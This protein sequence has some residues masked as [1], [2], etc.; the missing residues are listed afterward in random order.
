MFVE[1]LVVD[2]EE[3]E[4]IVLCVI[5]LLNSEEKMDSFV[6]VLSNVYVFILRKFYVFIVRLLKEERWK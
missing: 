6:N 1:G 4:V 2:G 5:L 3:V